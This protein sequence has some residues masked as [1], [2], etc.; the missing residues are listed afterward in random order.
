MSANS[1]Q[2]LAIYAG[3]KAR[4][5]LQSEGLQPQHVAVIPAAAGGPKGLMLTRLDQ[6][7]FGEWLP[8]SSQ[9]V[10]LVGASIGAW[11]MATACMPNSLAGMQR[12]EHDY[13]RQRY[14]I[15][16]GKR[17]P[18]S[19]SV[20]A[21]FANSLHQFYDG[22]VAQLLAHP[23]YKLHV[24]TSRGQHIL[25]KQGTWR[26]P[27]GYAGA[28]M[29]NAVSRR[30]LGA[31][32]E[33]VVF[34]TAQANGDLARLP[35]ATNDL[36]TQHCALNANNFYQALQASCSIPFALDA[37]HNI[38]GAPRG[39]YWDGGITDYHLHMQYQVAPQQVVLYPH[40]QQAVVPGWLDK[41]LRSRHKPTSALD[42]MVVIAP[43][44]DW[45]RSLPNA[46]LPDR[47]DFMTYRDDFDARVRVWQQAVDESQRLVDELQAWLQ[48]PDM[49]QVLPL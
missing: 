18:S 41:Q 3:P 13:V 19:S 24:I 47:H 38:P 26:T 32:L 43:K 7:L 23:R 35:F 5:L 36:A 8:Q 21:A 15:P 34:S 22:H 31:W 39:A 27:L 30:A 45:V 10:D 1:L 42:N 37:V 9:P 48:R 12:L 20:S 40:F 44:P 14:E 33:R 29:A 28:F 46:K 16:P 49:R 4:A 17:M 6:F 11:R 2:A 25:H